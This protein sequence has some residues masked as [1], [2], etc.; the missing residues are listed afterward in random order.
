MSHFQLDPTTNTINGEFSGPQPGNPNYVELEETD[1]RVVAW[2]SPTE[3]T[4]TMAIQ[5]HI[6]AIAAARSYGNGISCASYKDSTNVQWA[7]EATTFIA[8]RDSVWGY[9]FTELAKVQAGTRTQP[10]VDDFITE[11][12][13]I[14]WP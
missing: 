2:R 1:A 5:M 14:V 9:A 3:T 13:A 4:Y 8:W 11:L 12:P 6:D 7:S 10:T